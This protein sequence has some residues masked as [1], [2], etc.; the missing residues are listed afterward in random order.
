MNTGGWLTGICDELITCA[1]IK[2]AIVSPCSKKIK[3]DIDKIVF[4]GFTTP[5]EEEFKI[6]LN[7]FSP[8]VIHIFGT[9]SEHALCMTNAAEKLGIINKVVVSIQGMVS[10]YAKHFFAGLPWGAI[11]AASLRDIIKKKNIYRQQKIFVKNGIREEQ[12]IKK[13]KHIIGRT[14]WDQACVER[15][16]QQVPRTKN[17]ER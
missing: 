14:D 1:D 12:I 11:H 8:D 15:L 7:D 16:V 5:S 6:I 17:E 2:L 4:Y 9:E 10:V 13:V 3:K